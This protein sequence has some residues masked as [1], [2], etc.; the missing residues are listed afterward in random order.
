M[1]RFEP[2]DPS[3]RPTVRQQAEDPVHRRRA[4]VAR[5]VRRAKRVGYLALVIAIVGFGVGVVAG[6]SPAVVRIVVV[7]LVATCVILP[8]PIVVGYGVRA[9]EREDPTRRRGTP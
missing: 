9:A 1:P 8:V 3:R 5:W 4:E 7:A 2:A 6:F